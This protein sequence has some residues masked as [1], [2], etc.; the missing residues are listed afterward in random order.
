[1]GKCD[2]L[3]W[4]LMWDEGD[5]ISMGLG[6]LWIHDGDAWMSR[7]ISKDSFKAFETSLAWS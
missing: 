4:F 7:E 2:L 6:A 5:D 3:F 1:M